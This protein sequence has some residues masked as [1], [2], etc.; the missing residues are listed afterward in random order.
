MIIA[1]TRVET[2]PGDV[3][4]AVHPEDPRYSRFIG[5]Q[6]WHPIRE[7]F[8]PI[9]GESSVRQDFG[10]GVVKITPA[11]HHA[12]LEIAERHNLEIIDVIGND[13]TMTSNAGRFEVKKITFSLFIDEIS[14]PHRF[15]FSYNVLCGVFELYL[16]SRKIC[17]TGKHFG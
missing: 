13:G 15:N 11:H 3:A 12:D 7:T 10:T 14:N 8:I 6:V 1:T 2:M 16:G 9:I 17:S 5:Q 4:I